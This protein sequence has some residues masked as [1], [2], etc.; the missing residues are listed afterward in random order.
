MTTTPP[1]A[2]NDASRLAITGFLRSPL[3]KVHPLDMFGLGKA[4]DCRREP[5]G[6]KEFQTPLR[7]L[8]VV[9]ESMRGLA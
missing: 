8:G 3:Q 9:E 6:L 5:V 4:V 7:R 2:V 1:G